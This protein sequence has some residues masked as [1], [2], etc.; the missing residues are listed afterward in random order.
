MPSEGSHSSPVIPQLVCGLSSQQQ[1]LGRGVGKDFVSYIFMGTVKGSLWAQVHTLQ[2]DSLISTTA[3]TGFPHGWS[4]SFGK[5]QVIASCTLK[6]QANT[7]PLFHGAEIVFC[8]SSKSNQP[9]FFK[10]PFYLLDTTVYFWCTFFSNSCELMA[11]KEKNS[12]TSSELF[13]QRAFEL[14]ERALLGHLPC[15]LSPGWL[16]PFL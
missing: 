1:G 12:F 10:S 5:G 8:P 15:V 7:Q 4:A 16:C 14:K 2:F 6:K 11:K 9:L 13:A 3:E